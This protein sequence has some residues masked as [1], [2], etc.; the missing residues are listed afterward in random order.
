MKKSMIYLWLFSGFCELLWCAFLGAFKC[1]FLV[2]PWSLGVEIFFWRVFSLFVSW[3]T[4]NWVDDFFF[5]FWKGFLLLHELIYRELGRWFFLRVFS[6]SVSWVAESC[7]DDFFLRVFSLT[8]SWSAESWT[9]AWQWGLLT[10]RVVSG[11]GV[12][13]AHVCWC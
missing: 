8:V 11:C 2:W 6:L 5:F 13:L 4:E 3:S 7:G 12:R 9:W 10:P 1:C